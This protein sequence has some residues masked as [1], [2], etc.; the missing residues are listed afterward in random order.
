MCKSPPSPTACQCQAEWLPQITSKPWFLQEW[1]L[2][3]GKGPSDHGRVNLWKTAQKYMGVRKRSLRNQG[4][5]SHVSGQEQE[6]LQGR[7]SHSR[8]GGKGGGKRII[9]KAQISIFSPDSEDLVKSSTEQQR[10]CGLSSESYAL[11]CGGNSTPGLWC[12]PEN[13]PLV[14]SLFTSQGSFSRSN[15]ETKSGLET[16]HPAC[17]KGQGVQSYS[18]HS[19]IEIQFL[20]F[21]RKVSLQEAAERKVRGI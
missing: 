17:V 19:Q 9:V 13:R 14:S 3:E 15:T 11:T 21:E 10:A 6:E 16:Q 2:N 1:T 5:D 7:S 18:W 20:G 8:E 4:A 12:S